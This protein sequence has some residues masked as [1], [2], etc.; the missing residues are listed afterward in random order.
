MGL[1]GI[2]ANIFYPFWMFKQYAIFAL[3]AFIAFMPAVAKCLTSGPKSFAMNT[4]LFDFLSKLPLGKTVFSGICNLVTPYTGSIGSTVQSLTQE[5]CVVTMQD[6]SWL[7]NPFSSI[8]AVALTNL[9]EFAS[10]MALVSYMQ[11]FKGIKGIP[12]RIDTTFY[13]K[14]RG[15]ITATGLVPIQEFKN[16]LEDEQFE[17]VVTAEMTNSKGEKL[18]VTKV[19]WQIRNKEASKTK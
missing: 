3:G 7:R 16:H 6:R 4:D 11:H 10:G 9:G 18:A 13:K 5:K 17:I 14:S 8:H 1:D 15:E 19:Y 12:T 2:K